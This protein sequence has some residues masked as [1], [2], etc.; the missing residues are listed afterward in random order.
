[1]KFPKLEKLVTIRLIQ[2]HGPQLQ[3]ILLTISQGSDWFRNRKYF[4]T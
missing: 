1:M 3:V 2:K 4:R